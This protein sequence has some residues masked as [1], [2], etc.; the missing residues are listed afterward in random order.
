MT[1]RQVI[2]YTVRVWT[3]RGAPKEDQTIE[4][5]VTSA[6]GPDAYIN[7]AMNEVIQQYGVVVKPCQIAM[8][9]LKC[10]N[11]AAFEILDSKGQGMVHYPNWL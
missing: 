5:S 9:I 10:P 7:V 2:G 1:K 3:D 11:I 6:F 8:A 4:Q